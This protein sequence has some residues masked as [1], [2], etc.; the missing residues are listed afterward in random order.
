MCR[1]STDGSFTDW[2]TDG[3]NGEY[4]GFFLRHAFYFIGLDELA[5]TCKFQ[6]L[7]VRTSN[8]KAFGTIKLFLD[9]AFYRT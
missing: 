3:R 6:V 5:G 4:S 9:C 8:V 1:F 7:I 2:W